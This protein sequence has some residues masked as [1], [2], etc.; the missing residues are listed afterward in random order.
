MLEWISPEEGREST[1][2]KLYIA[3]QPSYALAICDWKTG[4]GYRDIRSG[5]SMNPTKVA[6]INVPEEENEKEEKEVT[7]ETCAKLDQNCAIFQYTG[8]PGKIILTTINKT[9]FCPECGKRLRRK[10]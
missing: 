5:L 3:Y 7:C 10:T 8:E 4:I 2:K 6:L 1:Y 9:F